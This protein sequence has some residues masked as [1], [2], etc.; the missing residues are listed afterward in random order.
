MKLIDAQAKADKRAQEAITA[1]PDIPEGAM[2]SLKAHIAAEVRKAGVNGIELR[3]I[4]NRRR[5]DK[6]GPRFWQCFTDDMWKQAAAELQS[7]WDKADE[8]A[9]VEATKGK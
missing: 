6:S 4:M 7:E 2:A 5:N 8:V 9:A 3:T 1:E